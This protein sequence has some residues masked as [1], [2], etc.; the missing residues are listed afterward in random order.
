MV[1]N[2]RFSINPRYIIPQLA[3][4][5]A[6]HNAGQ[7]AWHIAWQLDGG[8]TR[9]DVRKQY[10]RTYMQGVVRRGRR[11]QYNVLTTFFKPFGGGERGSNTWDGDVTEL[12]TALCY[13]YSYK[14]RVLY[15]CTSIYILPCAHALPVLVDRSILRAMT[16]KKVR[17]NLLSFFILSLSK[18]PLLVTREGFNL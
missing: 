4:H 2:A 18:G 15:I 14:V 10:T 17:P 7:I 3:W 1:A 11:W 5:L 13:T 12:M 8:T 16:L 9:N 6:W